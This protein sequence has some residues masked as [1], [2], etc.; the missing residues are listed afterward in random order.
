MANQPRS[1]GD[2]RDWKEGDVLLGLYEVR[3]LIARGG[4][5]NVYLVRHRGWDVDVAVKCPKADI[6]ASERGAKLF[7]QECETWVNLG[8][9]P[10]VANC[11]YVRRIDNIPRVFAEYV[12]GGTLSSWIH[13]RHLYKGKDVL[14]RMLDVAIQFAWGLRYAHA[15]GLLHQDVKPL[16]VLMTTDGV[17]KVTDFGLSRALNLASAEGEKGL[18]ASRGLGSRGTPLYCS[19]EQAYRRPLTF[20]TDIWSWAV[21]ILEMFVGDVTWMAGQSAGHALEG[22]LVLGP[23]YE[24]IP[25]MPEPLVKLLRQCFREDPADRPASMAEVIEASMAVYR[26]AVH[27][28]Y[29]R[30]VPEA[31]ETSP[32]RLNN[33]AVSYLDLGKK[34][35]ARQIWER[36]VRIE[37]W[38]P[39]STYNYTLHAW[40]EGLTTDITVMRTATKLRRRDPDSW[41]ARYMLA[42]VQAER[43]DYQA[44]LD[45]LSQLKDESVEGHE[46][47]AAVEEAQRR[48][49][50]TRRLLRTFGA[51]AGPVTA[52]CLS[53]DAHVALSADFPENADGNLYAWNVERGELIHTFQ[54]H[55]GGIASVALSA[56]GMHVVSGSHDRSVRVWSL[57]SGECLHKFK[58]H[59]GAVTGV[60]VTDDGRGV[61]SASADGTIRCWDLNEGKAM[62]TFRGHA[63]PVNAI[64][65]GIPGQSFYSAGH[66]RTLRQWEIRSGR[67]LGVEEGY[68][69]PFLC[70]AASDNRRYILAGAADGFIELYDVS[71]S[72]RLGRRRAHSE[73]VTAVCMSKRGELA[74]SAVR[75]D[76]IRLWEMAANRCLHT[77]AGRAPVALGGDGQLALSAGPDGVLHLWVV[78][79][80]SP[81]LHAPMMLCHAHEGRGNGKTEGDRNA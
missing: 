70:M 16:N 28:E 31:A 71:Q 10:N 13:K 36:A 19:P 44:A 2:E 51:H 48:L 5:G 35:E 43:G 3:S 23:E 50:E 18:R 9:H 65:P 68:L 69:A 54:G 37:P 34:E 57:A 77:Y 74:L 15:Q 8:L 47:R 12:D 67:C 64:C 73:P 32:D 72:K 78:S 79:C 62:G 24:A 55:H 60:L 39:E 25:E 76:K 11:Y 1:T 56:D 59:T 52:A 30:P 4:M 22:Y 58:E 80:G 6:V 66:D 40:R 14:V 81:V 33:R 46:V 41:K 42:Q 21:S 49:P 53:W 63:G 61:L 26:D 75:G 27:R 17:A 38:H 29:P 7:E 20:A 45:L